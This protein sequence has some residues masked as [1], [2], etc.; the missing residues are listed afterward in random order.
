MRTLAVI[1]MNKTTSILIG[2]LASVFSMSGQNPI[3]TSRINQGD[4]VIL[5]TRYIDCGEWGGHHEKVKIYK[6]NGQVWLRYSKD[7]V[8][9]ENDDPDQFRRQITD[10][11]KRI[12][13]NHLKQVDRY[14][15]NIYKK[16]KEERYPCSNAF[17]V[18]RIEAK[19][20]EVEFA[21]SCTN[22]DDFLTL[23]KKLLQ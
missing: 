6:A 15:K 4:T 23:C 19:G 20:D 14:I 8:S 22:W 7:T 12:N 3:A 16:S 17:R 13:S 1:I 18:F 9:C 11:K 5:F 2:L 10:L 21:D